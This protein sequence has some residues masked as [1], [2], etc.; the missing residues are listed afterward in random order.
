MKQDIWFVIVIYK[1]DTV[2]LGRLQ[3]SL[4]GKSVIIVDNSRKNLGFGGGANVG[5]GKALASG[6][7]WVVILNQDIE[8]TKRVVEKF[9]EKLQSLAPGI[10]GPFAGSLDK[11]RWT[12]VLPSK[13]VDYISGACMAIHRNVFE[14]IGIFYEPYFMYYEDADLSIRAKQHGFPIQRIDID[15][16]THRE[17]PVW[18]KG[19]QLHEYYLARN[20]FWFVMR[21]APWRI[22]LHEIVRF[23][24]TMLELIRKI[25][26]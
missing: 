5:I 2:V 6:A 10:A 17:T 7:Q 11:K 12:T 15:G 4:I 19:S 13:K 26:L 9:Y 18:P 3:K 21:L 20:H 24:K 16:I 22:K 23:P 14:K 25:L 1:P 8:L